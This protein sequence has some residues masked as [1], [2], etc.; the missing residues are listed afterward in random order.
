MS[1]LRAKPALNKTRFADVRTVTQ[2]GSTNADMKLLLSSAGSVETRKESPQVSPIV[3]LADHQTAGRGRLDRTWQA[4]PGTS[5][6]MTIGLPLV[7]I[8]GEYQT[9]LTT[10][11]ALSVTDATQKLGLEQVRIKWPNDLVCDAGAVSGAEEPT[12]ATSRDE[13]PRFGYF[14]LGGILAELH[15]IPGAGSCALLGLG[16]NVN[17]PEVPTELSGIASSL[18][19][20]VG[21]EID[22]EELLIQILLALDARWLPM[23][24]EPAGDLSVMFDTYRSRSATIGS[25]VRVV[26]PQGDLVGTAA[27]IA[28]DG[29]LLLR[30]DSG[31]EHVVTVGDVVH[32]RPAS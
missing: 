16:L 7:G 12:E 25:R 1:F 18:N 10:C 15:Q 21:H 26:L 13:E 11:L 6:L 14:K 31:V 28:A 22:R 32:A 27:D 2:T 3:L 8:S 24:E 9:W 4:P 19:K 20:V 30:D 5:L 17:W 29:A 23:L